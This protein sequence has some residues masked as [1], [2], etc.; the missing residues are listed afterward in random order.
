MPNIG[1]VKRAKDIGYKGS[2]LVIYEACPQCGKPRW[3]RKASH[4]S[5]KLCPECGRKQG[6][7]SGIDNSREWRRASELGKSLAKDSIFY[8][9][10]CSLCGTALW[11]RRRDI[12]KRVCNECHKKLSVHFGKSHGM[13]DGGRHLR[14]DGYMEVSLTPG[15]PYYSMLNKGGRVLEHRLV[16][17]QYLGRCLSPQEVV[18]HINRNRQDNRIE[19]LELL[20]KQSIHLT[21]NLAE[22]EIK[23]LQNQVGELRSILRLLLWHMTQLRQGNPELN[24][25]QPDKCVETM[26]FVSPKRR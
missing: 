18:H 7:L 5:T 14:K 17:A 6:A 3:H 25:G 1:E 12:G 8:K 11:H 20:P 22:I 15:S 10:A 4:P 2:G 26:G 19:N 9:D 23:K 16:M 24:S 21:Y 13:W